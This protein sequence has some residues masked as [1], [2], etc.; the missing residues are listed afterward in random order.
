MD[1]AIRAE[2]EAQS[3]ALRTELKQWESSWAKTNDGKKP[4]RDDIKQHPDI[5]M[6]PHLHPARPN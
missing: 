1:D 5:G 2:Y 6:Q 4:S 3:Q